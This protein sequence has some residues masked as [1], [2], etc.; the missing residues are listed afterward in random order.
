MK[1]LLIAVVGILAFMVVSCKKETT[2]AKVVNLFEEMT[3]KVSKVENIA[4]VEKLSQEVEAKMAELEKSDPDYEPTGEDQKR[5]EEAMS[6]YQEE[7]QK[8]AMKVAPELLNQME[9]MKDE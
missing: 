9:K 7:A 1:K 3:E 4:D 8:M 5:V 6:K 2:T